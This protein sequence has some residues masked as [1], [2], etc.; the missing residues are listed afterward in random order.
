MGNKPEGACDRWNAEELAF[1]NKWMEENRNNPKV[2]FF[3]DYKFAHIDPIEY[4]VPDHFEK[5]KMLKIK[6]YAQPSVIPKDEPRYM[7]ILFFIHGYG[8]HAARSAHFAEMFS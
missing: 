7:G 6:N 1:V 8:D 2:V 5:S 3:Q 4:S